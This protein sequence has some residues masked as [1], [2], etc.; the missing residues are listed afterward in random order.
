MSQADRMLAL[1]RVAGN[2]AV[3]TAVQRQHFGEDVSI[4]GTL[5]VF[6]R[7]ETPEA[8]A[9]SLRAGTLVVRKQHYGPQPKRMGK[10]I[11]LMAPV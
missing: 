9:E 10:T 8:D 7:I 1:Q 3:T 6:G 4:G 2:K 5:R 11:T